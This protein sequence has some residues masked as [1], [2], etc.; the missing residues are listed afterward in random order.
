MP[1][2]F[3]FY[4]YRFHFRAVDGVY[5]PPGKSANVVRG[6]FG[7]VLH[8]A[9]PPAVYA[10]LFEPGAELARSPSG[11]ADWPR[12]FVLRVAHLDGLTIH[13]GQPF[14]LDAHVFDL[15]Q[16]AFEHFRAAFILLA[17]KGLGPGRGRAELVRCEQLDLGDA[18]REI[19]DAPGAPS[20]IL[21]DPQADAPPAVTVQFV[22]P[23]EL[24][25]HG[26]VAGRPEFPVLFSR[27]RDRVSTLRSLYGAGPLEVDFRAMGER[28]AAVKMTRCTIAWERVQRKSGRTGQVH[29]I[30][31]F[32]GE[33]T[34]QGALGEFLPWLR[35]ARWVGVG[36]QTVWGKGD[37]RVV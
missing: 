19:G 13:P 7:S 30:G 37:V 16:P 11:L 14:H 8:E 10:R 36:R 3:E 21:L 29:S 31:G 12:P 23:T 5:L 6:A 28:A 25:A 15:H 22:T 4:R 18:A 33:A 35:A 1:V 17:D 2:T 26:D 20:S 27:L 32:T 24:K 9:V 34:Y